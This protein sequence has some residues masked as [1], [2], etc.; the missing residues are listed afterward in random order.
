[1]E[2]FSVLF[3][4]CFIP[5]SWKFSLLTSVDQAVQQLQW[6]FIKQIDFLQGNFIKYID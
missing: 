5:S 6:H 2:G 4:F 3:L 1:M